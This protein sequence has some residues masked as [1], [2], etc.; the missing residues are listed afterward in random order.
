MKQG[1]ADKTTTDHKVAHPT[2]HDMSPRG[3]SQY[4]YA[5]GSRLTS[6]GHYTTENSAL[7]IKQGRGYEGRHRQPK[8][9]GLAAAEPST[10]LEHKGDINGQRE[11]RRVGDNCK[12]FE[13]HAESQAHLGRGTQGTA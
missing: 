13:G 7:P 4:G 3:V 1:R 6:T 12:R 2:T 5:T 11:D 10:S 9:L 8:E